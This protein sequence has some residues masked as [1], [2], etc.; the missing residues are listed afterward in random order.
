MYKFRKY[1]QMLKI[2]NSFFHL[3]EKKMYNF[4][5]YINT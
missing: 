5:S 1:Y 3:L 2:I 4:I